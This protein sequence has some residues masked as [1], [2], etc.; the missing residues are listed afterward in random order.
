MCCNC[1][2]KT[3]QFIL[4]KGPL[5]HEESDDVVRASPQGI[6]QKLREADRLLQIS[7]NVDQLKVPEYQTMHRIRCLEQVTAELSLG[8]PWPV[9]NTSGEIH[10][11]GSGLVDNLELH[12]ERHKGITFIVYIDYACC[13]HHDNE[14]RQQAAPIVQAGALESLQMGEPVSIVASTL[15][16]ALEELW[17]VGVDSSL[18]PKFAPFIEF[19]AP[20]VWWYCRRNQL[21]TRVDELTPEHLQYILLFQTY[22]DKS[23]GSEYQIVGQLLEDSQIMT[24]YLQYLYVCHEIPLINMEPKV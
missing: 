9:R 19:N 21:R 18:P 23:L 22:L 16:H 15:L 11:R 4:T 5:D 24:K 10:L 12:L 7:S 14:T 17:S 3:F 6:R 1:L 2:V 13:K 20:Y 8:E